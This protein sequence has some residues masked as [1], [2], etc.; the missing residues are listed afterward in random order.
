MPL[1]YGERTPS[2]NQLEV[3]ADN[4]ELIVVAGN[5]GSRKTT[6]TFWKAMDFLSKYSTEGF[7]GRWHKKYFYETTLGL[8]RELFPAK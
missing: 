8:W 3:M 2:P 7:L 6:V 5:R 4:H 1:L